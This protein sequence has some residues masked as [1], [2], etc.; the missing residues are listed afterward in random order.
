MIELNGNI[1]RGRA[2]LTAPFSVSRAVS[3]ARNLSL[4]GVSRLRVSSQV[5]TMI[6]AEVPDDGSNESSSDDSSTPGTFIDLNKD[7]HPEAYEVVSGGDDERDDGNPKSMRQL[8]GSDIHDEY[9]DVLVAVAD[10]HFEQRPE[11][12]IEYAEPEPADILNFFRLD[13][14]EMTLQDVVEEAKKQQ[15]E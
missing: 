10:A 1:A 12:V 14:V 3:G 2:R 15:D 8:L 9:A 7:D 4:A 5:L 6:D 13:E 11:L